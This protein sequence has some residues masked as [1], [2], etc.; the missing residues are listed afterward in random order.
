MKILR[1][2]RRESTMKT[3]AVRAQ[4]PYRKRMSVDPNKKRR[5]FNRWR[6]QNTQVYTNVLQYLQ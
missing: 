6:L 2:A 1:G 4:G 3:C 5:V